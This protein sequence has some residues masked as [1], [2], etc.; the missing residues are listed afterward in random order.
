MDLFQIYYLMAF[1][2]ASLSSSKGN[3]FLGRFE[4]VLDLAL[5]GGEFI[6]SDDHSAAVP[7]AVGVFEL[8]F[9]VPL[10]LSTY[11]PR[12]KGGIVHLNRFAK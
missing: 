12:K 10:F 5:A 8:A 3:G 9:E 4:Q 11:C 6:V 7:F 2:M 1:L